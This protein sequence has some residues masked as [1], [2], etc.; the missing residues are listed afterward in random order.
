[1][2]VEFAEQYILTHPEVFSHEESVLSGIKKLMEEANTAIFTKASESQSNFGMGTT[3][4]TVVMLNNK[5]YIGHVGDSRVYLI[6]DGVIEKVT[7]DH[8]FIEELI[9]NGSLTREEAENH[10]KKNVITRALGCDQEILVDTL[11][12]E[13]KDEDIFV[14]CTDG[15]TNM[16][17]EDEILDIILKSEDPETAC[18]ELVHCANEK[19]GEDNITV[20]II[21]NS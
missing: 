1:M 18:N 20:I 12:V 13:V 9:K 4:I 16:L 11:T 10:P 5:M 3:F 6:R 14:L 17:R 21:K 19:G 7:T 2:A 8:S 15:L